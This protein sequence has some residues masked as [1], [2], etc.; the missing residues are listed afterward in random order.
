MFCRCKCGEE[1]A[2]V[3]VP[4][5]SKLKSN[6]FGYVT[7]HEKRKPRGIILP[8]EMAERRRAELLAHTYM[9]LGIIGRRIGGRPGVVARVG[10]RPGTRK[11]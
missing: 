9:A 4:P 1:T 6:F 5:G 10:K 8:Q 7:G 3:K 2:R 11:G